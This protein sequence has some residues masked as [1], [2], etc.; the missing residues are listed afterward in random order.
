M[1]AVIFHYHALQVHERVTYMY[2]Y[3]LVPS[4][5]LLVY[6]HVHMCLTRE[7]GTHRNPRPYGRHTCMQRSHV[8]K[9]SVHV[10]I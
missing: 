9:S 1:Q 10:Y 2:T 4:T 5:L 3:I 8:V 7:S 6:V